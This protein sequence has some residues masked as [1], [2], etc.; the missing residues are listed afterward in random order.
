[1]SLD[2]IREL[3]GTRVLVIHPADEEIDELIR[4]LRRIGCQTRLA[5]PLPPAL[6]TDVDV[7]FFSIWPTGSTTVPE[8]AAEPGPSLIAIVDFENPT[9]LRSLLD[10]NAHSFV[11]KPIRPSGILSSLVMARA[12]HGYQIRLLNK[13]AKLE[14]TL[15]SRRE[16]ERATRI[17]M[18][19]KGSSEDSAYQLIRQQATAQRLAMGVVARSIITAHRVFDKSV[20][21]NT[22]IARETRSSVLRLPVRKS[23]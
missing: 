9:A 10:T 12:L 6:P 19:V 7:V 14:E 13:V 15:R 2:P 11:S 17:L 20:E 8:S 4:H 5:W 22:R 16:I 23:P 21:D 3:R 1:M 18:E